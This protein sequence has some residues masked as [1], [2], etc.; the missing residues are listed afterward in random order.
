MAQP[1]SAQRAARLSRSSSVVGR[2]LA[3]ALL[4]VVMLAASASPAGAQL[5]ALKKLKVLKDAV[6]G[7]DSAARVKDSLAKIG[8]ASCRE[9]VLYTV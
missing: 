4:T 5:G 2:T 3:V 9:R 8:R 7:P 6:S 1:S